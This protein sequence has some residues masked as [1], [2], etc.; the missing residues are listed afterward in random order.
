MR[1]TKPE[2]RDNRLQELKQLLLDRNY[3]ENLIDFSISRARKI[4]R[5]IALKKVNNKDTENRPVFALKFDPRLPAVANIQA[6]HWRSMTSQD[7]YLSDV[8]P[9][10]PL[11]AFRRQ[12]NL[13]NFLIKSKI[14][15]P[16]NTYPK[17]ELCGMA[18]CGKSCPVCPFIKPGK[19]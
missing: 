15:P 4:S 19:R 5:K 9:Q 16:A 13:R 6:K 8:F 14:P 10:P 12:K 18:R 11:T 1:C 2:T 17:R 3:P 7:R